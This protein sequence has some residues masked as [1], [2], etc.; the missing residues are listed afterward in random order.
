MLPTLLLA[1]AL[2][3]ATTGPIASRL[4]FAETPADA[5][6]TR[7]LRHHE[8]LRIDRDFGKPEFDLVVDAWSETARGDLAD[9]RL[10]WVKT[11]ANDRRSPLSTKAERYVDIDV[12]RDGPNS[13]HVSVRGGGRE[14]AFDVELGKGGAHVFT[15]VVTKD[16]E[17]VEHCRTTSSRLIARRVMGIPVGLGALQVTCIDDDGRKVRGRA[18]LRK[19]R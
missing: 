6:S 11:T 14:F 3:S 19:V 10:W 17:T 16:G 13:M 7:A 9:V 15:D 2:T 8:A 12:R 5:L 18:S 4:P 1:S